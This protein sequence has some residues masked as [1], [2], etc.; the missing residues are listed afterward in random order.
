MRIPDDERVP[1]EDDGEPKTARRGVAEFDIT[2]GEKITAV[3]PADDDDESDDDDVS[4][5]PYGR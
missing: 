1:E 2:T 4:V 3:L 5:P